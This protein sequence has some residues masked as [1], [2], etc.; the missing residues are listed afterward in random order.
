MRI[1]Y[2]P[3]IMEASQ[4]HICS[5]LLNKCH[6]CVKIKMMT[7]EEDQERTP[8]LEKDCNFETD[9]GGY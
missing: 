1:H 7:D 3:H 4:K 5:I 6:D 8:H 2:D 9:E